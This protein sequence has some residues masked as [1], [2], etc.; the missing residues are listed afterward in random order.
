MYTAAVGKMEMIQGLLWRVSIV[1][2]FM[3][4][5]LLVVYR[6]LMDFALADEPSFWWVMRIKITFLPLET[7]KKKKI[8]KTRA[9][10]KV[11]AEGPK[12]ALVTGEMA[13]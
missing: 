2:I 10:L 12:R 8:S 4:Y 13:H 7:K 1:T 11:P 9:T 5:G 6:M 3:I